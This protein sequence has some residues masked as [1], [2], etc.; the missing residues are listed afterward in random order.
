MQDATVSLCMRVCVHA[1]LDTVEYA[2]SHPLQ[3]QIEIR[4]K[5]GANKRDLRSR[6]GISCPRPQAGDDIHYVYASGQ[7]LLHGQLAIA[8]AA[9]PDLCHLA[10]RYEY[11]PAHTSILLGQGSVQLVAS[12][13]LSDPPLVLFIYTLTAT[14]TCTNSFTSPS[15]LRANATALKLTHRRS[16]GI[17]TPRCVLHDSPSGLSLALP[18]VSDRSLRNT[19]L[20]TSQQT[21]EASL[22]EDAS[23]P[24]IWMRKH[25]QLRLESFVEK[26]I[27][28]AAAGAAVAPAVAEE[29]VDAQIVGGVV[30]PPG[31]QPFLVGLVQASVASDYQAQFCGGT[32]YN[33]RYVITAAHCVDFITSTSSVAILVGT[34]TL[35]TTGQGRRIGVSSI[36][37]NS[38]WNPSTFNFD[39]AVIR[40][41]TAVTDIPF[42]QLAPRNT[43]PT[44][45]A[46][47]TVS[48]WGTT[49]YGGSSPAQLRTVVVPNWDRATCNGPSSYNGQITLSMFCAGETGKDSC[50]GDSGG[51]ITSID[52]TTLIGIVSWGD[53]CAYPLKPGVYARVGN[54]DIHDFITQTASLVP[55]P[56]PV[57]TPAPT[58]SPTVLGQGQCGL[59]YTLTLGANAFNNAPASGITVSTAGT[60]CNFGATGYAGETPSSLQLCQHCCLIYRD[61]GP[62]IL[63]NSHPRHHTASYNSVYY[64]FTPAQT[65]TYTFSTC[66][67][68]NF[69]TKIIVSTTCDAQG[70][71]TCNDDG[72]GCSSYTSVTPGVTLNAGTRY[73]IIVGSWSEGT[74]VGSGT[75][76]VAGPPPTRAPTRSPTYVL[77]G[78]EYEL[79]L[80]PFCH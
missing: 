59:P 45:L 53:G 14:P 7:R 76:T 39:V 11:V 48:G 24:K 22:L 54:P 5:D 18:M 29:T 71:L 60:P 17:Q 27:G 10:C 65:A 37:I 63:D 41:A 47:S 68:A 15:P 32:L 9:T 67:S 49:S 70:L 40:L 26:T 73:Y 3:P 6:R 79:G 2:S 55:T 56:T 62:R 51:P 46:L 61:D 12:C 38:R 23:A 50:Q 36:T 1:K 35:S 33:E 66:N 42:A 69:D 31:L 52:N 19:P 16:C 78:R 4:G 77:R 72:S 21:Y 58:R 20:H 30:A 8:T 34:Q 43:E 28:A 75:I 25:V 64:Q 57:P 74:Q 80:P 44:P 13:T